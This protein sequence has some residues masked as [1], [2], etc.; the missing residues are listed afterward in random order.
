[1]FL[2]HN[3]NIVILICVLNLTRRSMA[4]RD[5]A[6]AKPA[7]AT[8]QV[9][10]LLLLPTNDTYKFSLTKVLSSLSLAIKELKHTDFGAKFKIDIIT[11]TCDC[12][13]ITA[14]VNAME[15]IYRNRNQTVRFQAVFGPMCD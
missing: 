3:I 5:V 14:P 8:T 12:T 11:D 7:T 13:G 15:N 9:N 1:M 4:Q 6:L 2:S 10:I